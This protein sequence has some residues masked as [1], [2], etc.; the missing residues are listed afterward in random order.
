MSSQFFQIRVIYFCLDF[1]RFSCGAGYRRDPDR[2]FLSFE[3][4]SGRRRVFLFVRLQFG[5]FF[6]DI[7][8]GISVFSGAR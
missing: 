8:L 7:F 4:F 5:L 6:S 2:G 3:F 1:S